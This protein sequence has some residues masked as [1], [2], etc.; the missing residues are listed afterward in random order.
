MSWIK[1]KARLPLVVAA[2]AGAIAA[3]GAFSMLAAG[4]EPEAG[5]HEGAEITSMPAPPEG[6][7]EL[8]AA[9]DCA[10]GEGDGARAPEIADVDS[11]CGLTLPSPPADLE[12]IGCRAIELERGVRPRD[13]AVAE[14]V[15]VRPPVEEGSPESG[16]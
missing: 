4:E 6:F 3:S 14:L 7:G 8:E 11:P 13:D 5:G 15:P 1:M 16:E 2:L 12:G 9:G 10:V